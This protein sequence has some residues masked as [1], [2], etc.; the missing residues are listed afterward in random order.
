MKNIGVLLEVADIIVKLQVALGFCGNVY[1][2]HVVK[3]I[4]LYQY[5]ELQNSEIAVSHVNCHFFP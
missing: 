1:I 4:E 3:C 2:L 5:I